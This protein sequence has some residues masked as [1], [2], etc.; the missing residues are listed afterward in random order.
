MF[1]NFS[2]MEDVKNAVYSVNTNG[3][4]GPYGL[5]V[6]CTRNSGILSLKMCLTSF[7]NADHVVVPIGGGAL[8]EVTMM[9]SL[10]LCGGWVP[11]DQAM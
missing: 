7:F 2:S 9:E 6:V 8:R 11:Q 10:N 3:T 5:E 4:P 1:T